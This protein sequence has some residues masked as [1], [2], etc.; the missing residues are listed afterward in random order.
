MCVRQRGSQRTCGA[1]KS[2]AFAVPSCP[3]ANL[4]KPSIPCLPHGLRNPRAAQL[5]HGTL[6]QVCH[7]CRDEQQ[8]EEWA[9]NSSR[10][11]HDIPA[12][13]VAART[14]FHRVEVRPVV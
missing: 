14:T 5:C 4:L 2:K 7:H 6:T 10:L 1:E 13:F 8:Y 3:H 11:F 9:S 12:S